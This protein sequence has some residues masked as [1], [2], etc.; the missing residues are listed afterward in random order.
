MGPDEL[1]TTRVGETAGKRAAGPAY[2]GARVIVCAVLGL[3]TAALASAGVAAPSADASPS[4]A[5]VQVGRICRDT[6]GVTPGGRAFSDC[7]D[8]LSQSAASLAQASLLRDAR[9]HCLKQGGQP[10]DR[11]LA[12]CV[13]AATAD[14]GARVGARQEGLGAAPAGRPAIRSY[15]NVSWREA[16]QRRRLACAALGYSP[17]SPGFYSCVASLQ[18]AL[19]RADHPST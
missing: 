15:F 9:E 19:F 13:V 7:V 3:S 14:K 2:V 18:A 6:V 16:H 10:D 12:T 8:E 17:E 5:A 11:A 4:G 1:A